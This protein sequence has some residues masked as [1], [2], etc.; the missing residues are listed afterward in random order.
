MLSVVFSPETVLLT[1]QH[2]AQDVSSGL[3]RRESGESKAGGSCVAFYDLV[4]KSQS[5]ECRHFR[6]GRGEAKPVK[7]LAKRTFVDNAEKFKPHGLG[8]GCGEG[9]AGLVDL[10]L[11]GMVKGGNAEGQTSLSRSQVVFGRNTWVK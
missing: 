5:V 6:A 2:E 4:S 8:W 3:P 9:G 7:A 1:Q 11:W 10:S